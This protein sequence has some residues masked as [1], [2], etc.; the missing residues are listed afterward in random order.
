MVFCYDEKNYQKEGNH[1]TFMKKNT[2]FFTH[3][4]LSKAEIV[5]IKIIH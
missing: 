5:R 3:I 4:L 1:A 2:F